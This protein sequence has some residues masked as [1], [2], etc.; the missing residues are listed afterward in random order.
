MTLFQTARD[1]YIKPGKLG[2]VTL[3]RT[4]WHG[5]VSSFVKPVPAELQTQ[6]SD[7]AWKRFIQPTDKNRPYHAYQFNCFR[8]FFDFG[9]SI[10]AV[11]IC[12]LCSISY[13]Q[14]RRLKYDIAKER[15]V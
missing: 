3:V 7:L 2:K 11:A 13:Q 8:A 4:G 15:S 14:G 9:G 6:P 5:S 12:H 1:E 10:R